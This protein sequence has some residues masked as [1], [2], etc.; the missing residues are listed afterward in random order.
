MRFHTVNAARLRTAGLSV[1]SERIAGKTTLA[2]HLD[3]KWRWSKVPNE[4]I[5]STRD[6]SHARLLSALGVSVREVHLGL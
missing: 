1:R 5:W 6:V 2:V 4:R 3:G